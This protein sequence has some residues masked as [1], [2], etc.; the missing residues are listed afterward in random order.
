MSEPAVPALVI[1]D[2]DCPNPG[3]QSVAI[4][5]RHPLLRELAGSPGELISMC[6]LPVEHLRDVVQLLEK[7][8]RNGEYERQHP[9][10]T[11]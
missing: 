10:R 2:C 11:S 6:Y 5:I 8:A 9:L 3:C 1:G 7:K 4:A